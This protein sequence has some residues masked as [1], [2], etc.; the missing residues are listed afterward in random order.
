LDPTLKKLIDNSLS[1]SE[2]SMLNI[3]GYPFPLDE[4]LYFFI[5]ESHLEKLVDLETLFQGYKIDNA[6]SF[7]LEKL[8][9]EGW[10]REEFGEFYPTIGYNPIEEN[11]DKIQD[12]TL[13]EVVKFLKFI[14]VCL[15]DDIYQ[16]TINSEIA[17]RIIIDFSNLYPESNLTMEWFVENK[18][19]I[20]HGDVFFLKND[21]WQHNYFFNN[22]AA[23]H[24]DNCIHGNVENIDLQTSWFKIY[25]NINVTYNFFD[26][27]NHKES[28]IKLIEWLVK[29]ETSLGDI[30]LENK[31]AIRLHILQYSSLSNTYYNEIDKDR[32]YTSNLIENLAKIERNHWDLYH[33]TQERKTVYFISWLIFNRFHSFTK[34][35][36]EVFAPV[37]N[38]LLHSGCFKPFSNYVSADIIL[39]LLDYKYTQFCAVYL[40]F[41]NLD[42]SIV[43]E[44]THLYNFSALFDE[45]L[46]RR[47][48][49][50]QGL[51]GSE[52]GL[53]LQYI[54][55]KA[56]F[57]KDLPYHQS[58]SELFYKV[59][60]LLLEKIK[61]YYNSHQANLQ[62]ALEYLTKQLIPIKGMFAGEYIAFF[63]RL[64][65]VLYLS[66][67]AVPKDLC[68]DMTVN[69][70]KEQFLKYKEADSKLG[71]PYLDFSYWIS[72]V[73]LFVYEKASIHERVSIIGAPN[74][75]KIKKEFSKTHN[76]SDLVSVIFM[77]LGI[78]YSIA[79]FAQIYD[80]QETVRDDTRKDF[81]NRFNEILTFYIYD[82]CHVSNL[83]PRNCN[84]KRVV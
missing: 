24:W 79:Y 13:K 49:W 23:K 25:I 69:I 59:L 17:K 52:L 27:L 60:L 54:I 42:F 38:K 7:T 46:S 41:E 14:R 20:P 82:G 22:A 19:L 21:N 56:S 35:T 77:S 75:I 64:V 51:Q 50:E 70:L 44:K 26:V 72:P 61:L 62:I 71:V 16:V 68:Y 80:Y 10:I 4:I 3:E 37:F 58:K 45:I 11:I 47:W 9:K 5:K 84:K 33:G 31:I 67:T 55:R 76:S 34:D 30:D 39:S 78:A 40:L 43:P 48:A 18:I 66:E 15:Y 32:Y 1:S 12:S 65:E 81:Y 36:K 2:K 53:I 83:R 63:V 74:Y 29:K 73:W 6:V 28:F 8:K 57:K